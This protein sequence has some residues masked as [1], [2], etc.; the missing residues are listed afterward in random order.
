MPEIQSFGKSIGLF[1]KINQFKKHM[2]TFLN[3]NVDIAAPVQSPFLKLSFL[4][5]TSSGLNPQP[6]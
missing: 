2:S 6:K 3:E 1:Y 5:G 4:L